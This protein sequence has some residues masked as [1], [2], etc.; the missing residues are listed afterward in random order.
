MPRR[1]QSAS[2][3]PTSAQ[4]GLPAIRAAEQAAAASMPDPGSK[5]SPCPWR[6]ALGFALLFIVAVPWYWRDGGGE[7]PLVLG[8]PLWVAVST[9]VAFLIACLAAWTAFRAWPS[10]GDDPEGGS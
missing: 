8:L 3:F 5:K 2:R 7:S 9:G 10:D 4:F 6:L 1:R